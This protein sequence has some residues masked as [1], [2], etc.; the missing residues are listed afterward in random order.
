MLSLIWALSSM[1][2]TNQEIE[3][4][5]CLSL[6]NKMHFKGLVPNHWVLDSLGNSIGSKMTMGEPSEEK[7]ESC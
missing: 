5:M 4:V 3:E 2:M 1:K 6:N 7:Y